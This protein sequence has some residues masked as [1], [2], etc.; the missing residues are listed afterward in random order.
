MS[1]L[2]HQQSVCQCIPI[3]Q[4]ESSPKIGLHASIKRRVTVSQNRIMLLPLTLS[5]QVGQ[6]DW[7]VQ[8]EKGKQDQIMTLDEVTMLLYLEGHQK[9]EDSSAPLDAFILYQLNSNNQLL[10]LLDVELP[11]GENALMMLSINKRSHANKK[12][13]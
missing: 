10:R 13:K 7:I 11:M 5:K 1:G 6:Y 3:V 4:Q 9:M 8:Q 2:K 12:K